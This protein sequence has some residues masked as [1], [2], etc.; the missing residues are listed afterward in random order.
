MILNHPFKDIKNILIIEDNIYI[1]FI[2]TYTIYN[3]IHNYDDDYYKNI[4]ESIDNNEFQ[5]EEYIKEVIQNS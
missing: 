2:Q 1:T 5:D 4:L 3:Q